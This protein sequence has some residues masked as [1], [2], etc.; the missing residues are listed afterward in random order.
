MLCFAAQMCLGR[1]MGKVCRATDGWETV[2]AM[3]GSALQC[4]C[5]FRRPFAKLQNLRETSHKGKRWLYIVPHP[6]PDQWTGHTV[7][8][9]GDSQKM[10]ISCGKAFRMRW[11][12]VGKTSRVRSRLLNPSASW[13]ALRKGSALAARIFISKRR[14]RHSSRQGEGYLYL[15]SKANINTD[16]QFRRSRGGLWGPTLCPIFG[17][18]P[19]AKYSYIFRHPRRWR[20]PILQVNN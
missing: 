8:I 11:A 20:H 4:S 16:E 19:G 5:H 3:V 6:M 2:P 17:F 9:W 18:S 7:I 14:S 12:F 15:T 1:W 10:P 13:S